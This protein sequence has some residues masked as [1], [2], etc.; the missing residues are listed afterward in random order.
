MEGSSLFLCT[1][2]HISSCAHVEVRGQGWFC[3]LSCLSFVPGDNTG[4]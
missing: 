1:P 3:C 4:F 2:T